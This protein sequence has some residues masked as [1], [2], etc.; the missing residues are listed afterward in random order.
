M[1]VKNEASTRF[2]DEIRI[3]SPWANNIAFI[4]FASMVI[5]FSVL[6]PGDKNPPP[7]AGMV[8]VGI[9]LGVVLASYILLIG[10]INRDAG[11]RNMSRVLWTFVAILIPN[12]LGIVLYFILRKPRVTF[13]S[14]CNAVIEPGFGFCPNCRHRLAGTCPQC[15]RSVTGGG[16]YCP[17]C[18]A[19]LGT[20]VNA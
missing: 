17:Y 13:C 9:L 1:P 5:V 19:D 12:A 3:I 4:A 15:Q 14:Q 18:G 7:R 8:L 11:R 16:K 2:M 10:Y 20:V 6:T